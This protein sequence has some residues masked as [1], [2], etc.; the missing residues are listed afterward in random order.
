MPISLSLPAGLLSHPCPPTQVSGQVHTDDTKPGLNPVPLLPVK[1]SWGSCFMFTASISSS[2]PKWRL[3]G[4]LPHGPI[5]KMAWVNR[6]KT[7]GCNR[8]W[9]IVFLKKEDCYLY[10]WVIPQLYLVNYFIKTFI[11]PPVFSFYQTE[12]GSTSHSP[13][14]LWAQY[15][16]YSRA[17]I[18]YPNK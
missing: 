14:V 3:W 1:W 4:I 8:V 11:W 5:E 10:P 9:F 6:C 18:Y 17:S 12:F 16:E 13:W 2:F 15:L 7:V